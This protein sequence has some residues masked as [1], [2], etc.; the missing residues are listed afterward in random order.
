M[1]RIWMMRSKKSSTAP[2]PYGA[3]DAR[4]AFAPGPPLDRVA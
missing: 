4:I 1:I 3:R 2:K